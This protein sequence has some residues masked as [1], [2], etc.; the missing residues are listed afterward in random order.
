MGLGH[1][2][3]R[4]PETNPAHPERRVPTGRLLP[5]GPSAR[6]GCPLSQPLR[7]FPLGLACGPRRWQPQDQPPSA[8]RRHDMHLS[9]CPELQGWAPWS[10]P[11]LQRNACQTCWSSTSP[12]VPCASDPTG[13]MAPRG[14]RIDRPHQH[15]PAHGPPTCAPSHPRCLQ[16]AHGSLG[17]LMED[18]CSTPCPRGSCPTSGAVRAALSGWKKLLLEEEPAPGCG[19]SLPS[20][21]YPL[22]SAR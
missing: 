15:C 8:H 19:G 22:R 16:L 14:S 11:L 2:P 18:V 3:P 21:Q 4:A 6:W 20:L 5:Q 13:A 1:N 9:Q 7:R 10:L 12:G 17:P